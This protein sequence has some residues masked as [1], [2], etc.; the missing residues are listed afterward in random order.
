MQ[1]G[2]SPCEGYLTLQ[3]QQQQL[4]QQPLLQQQQDPSAEEN[5]V[6]AAT[7]EAVGPEAVETAPTH[8]SPARSNPVISPAMTR[9]RKKRKAVSLASPVDGAA[10]IQVDGSNSSPPPSPASTFPTTDGGGPPV[11]HGGLCA[12]PTAATTL[13]ALPPEPRAQLYAQRAWLAAT[14][15]LSICVTTVL[16]TETEN[17]YQARANQEPTLEVALQHRHACQSRAYP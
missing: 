14:G 7:A 12:L 5:T 4:P 9:A 8:A 13:V 3:Q 1:C 6:I 16:I 11:A 10:F 17:S 2:P 15:L